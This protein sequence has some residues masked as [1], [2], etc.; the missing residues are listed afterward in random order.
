MA[1]RLD[2]LTDYF[3]NYQINHAHYNFLIAS[4]LSVKL[5]F[6]FS[7]KKKLVF[8]K[9]FDRQNNINLYS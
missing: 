8:L 3:C 2:K 6:L 7:E 5:V 1:W 9:G 4:T